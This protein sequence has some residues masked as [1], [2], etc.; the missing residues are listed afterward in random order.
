FHVTGVQTCALPIWT[1]SPDG[2]AHLLAAGVPA[3]KIERVGNIMIDSFE[4]L[5]PKILEAGVAARLGL[6][7]R[8][9]G[10]VTLHR[11]SNVD[12]PEKIGRAA[13]RERG[14]RG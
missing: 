9:F 8:G 4:L 11:P 6:E 7:G 3:E 5:K 12:R 13:R 2:D 10:V 1:P 14:G